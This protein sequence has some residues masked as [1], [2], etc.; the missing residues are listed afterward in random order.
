MKRTKKRKKFGKH[1]KA[2]RVGELQEGKKREDR[3]GAMK[4]CVARPK[5]NG[6]LN[7]LFA[8]LYVFSEPGINSTTLEIVRVGFHPKTGKSQLLQSGGSGH[9]S[10]EKRLATK[11][12]T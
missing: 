7:F 5:E 3:K 10:L 8:P 6:H 4:K 2:S 9:S 1:W 11:G 12:F